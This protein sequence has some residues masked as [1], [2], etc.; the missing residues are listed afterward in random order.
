MPCPILSS[1]GTYD[2][3]LR[4][5]WNADAPCSLLQRSEL[6]ASQ[7]SNISIA[8]LR[9]DALNCSHQC[10]GSLI[11]HICSLCSIIE[12]DPQIAFLAFLAF[13]AFSKILTSQVRSAPPQ[14]LTGCVCSASSTG[15]GLQ[16]AKNT[17]IQ[18]MRFIE[19][20]FLVCTIDVFCIFCLNMQILQKISISSYF[21]L[22]PRF[23]RLRRRRQQ[24]KLS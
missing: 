12:T 18:K 15:Q 8:V 23:D 11:C 7:R 17:K 20:G 5:P 2:Q 22:C 3:H 4:S 10:N 14:V 13:S 9:S 19:L 21:R 16:S 1:I 6:I 24:H